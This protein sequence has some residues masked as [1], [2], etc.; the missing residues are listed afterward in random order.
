MIVSP[1]SKDDL[2]FV[3]GTLRKDPENEMYHLLARYSTY[4]GEGR[5]QG[6]LYDLGA[7]PGVFL[8][9]GCLDTVLGEVYALNSQNASRT[10]QALDNYEGCGPGHPEPAEY[11]R[12]Q[13]HILLDDGNEL[14]AWAY[15]LT[16][17]PHAAARVPGGD[18]LAWRRDRWKGTSL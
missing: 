18:Y 5:I 9:D 3:Y 6:E 14:N 16:N 17:L 2:L 13:V 12:Q 11:R 8:M 15:I 4:V 1:S 7:Y 10:W